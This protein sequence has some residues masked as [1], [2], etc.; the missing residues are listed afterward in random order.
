[1]ADLESSRDTSQIGE[2]WWAKNQSFIL[3]QGY[4]LRPRYEPNWVPSWTINPK[5][6]HEDG[7]KS[8]LSSPAMD[9]I[10]LVDGVKVVL[11]KVS[12]GGVELHTTQ[13]LS[14][15]EARSDPRNHTIPI[16][17]IIPMP[18]ENWTLLVM[19]YCRVFTD[20]PFH[21][22]AEVIEAMQQY[23]EGLQFMHDNHIAHSDIAPQNLMMEESQ[24]VP[25]GSHFLHAR[26]HDGFNKFFRC[27]NRCAVGPVKYY[28]IDFG[29]SMHFPSGQATASTVGTLRT[30]PT[31]PE[32]SQ[33]VPYNP[34]PVDIYQFGLML[35]RLIETYNGLDDFRPV[36][37]AMMN[38][39]PRE[40]PAAG[41]SLAQL[42]AIA[43]QMST[44]K[45]RAP[46]W[47]RN[48]FLDHVSR[49]LCGGYCPGRPYI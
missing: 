48:G 15:P 33:N 46:V 24:V 3:T 40:R 25:E 47:E 18:R 28:Y 1:M 30:F 34:F 26:T 45:R 27:K 41:Q 39:D 5:G 9:A 16:L 49:Q 32:L 35:Q 19:P 7:L 31:I 17:E 2:K 38:P 4:K 37:A 14:S 29:L 44:A 8:Y 36:A 21:C 6:D 23:L 12:K 22:R 10:R 11:K 13:L 20:P 43:A 42:N